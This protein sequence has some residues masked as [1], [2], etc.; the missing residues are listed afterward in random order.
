MNSRDTFSLQQDVADGGGHRVLLAV[1][2][3]GGL[4]H[5][6]QHGALHTFIHI[7]QGMTRKIFSIKEDVF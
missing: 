4:P 3:R 6:L 7:A 2:L 5:A 1:G